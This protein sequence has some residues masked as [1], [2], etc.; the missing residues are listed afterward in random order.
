[1]SFASDLRKLGSSAREKLEKNR[2]AEKEKESKE[3][4]RETA[5][6]ISRL[7]AHASRLLAHAENEYPKIL[8][9]LTNATKE[10]ATRYRYSLEHPGLED[11]RDVSAYADILIGKLRKDG[12]EVE[13]Y[14]FKHRC[15]NHRDSDSPLACTC[16]SYWTIGIQW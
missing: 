7:L 16:K 4:E 10:G 13:K 3:R 15:S 9:L 8:Q 2:E 5:E 11:R 6:R 12:F 1:M 14:Q